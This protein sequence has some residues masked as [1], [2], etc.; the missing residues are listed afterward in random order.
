VAGFDGGIFYEFG[1][2]ENFSIK[3]EVAFARKGGERDGLQPIPPTLLPPEFAPFLMGQQP[4]ASFDNR[5]VFSYITVPILAKYEWHL[6]DRWG[7]YVNGG[8]YADFILSPTQE[9]SGISPI[10][11]DPDG[12]I[13]IPDPTNPENP[14]LVDFNQESDINDDISDMDFGAMLGIGASYALDGQNEIIADIR[15]SYGF[16]PLQ[17]DTETYGD[18]FMGSLVFSIGYAYTFDK[19]SKSVPE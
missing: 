6:G 8:F 13:A 1:I 3:A 18:V 4:Y 9:T 12:N 19:K 5:A 10:F 11:L 2:T 16:V 15:G 17:K 14:L 7:V